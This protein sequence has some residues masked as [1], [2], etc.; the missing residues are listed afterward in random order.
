MKN[1]F[2][3]Q[4]LV[5]LLLFAFDISA[6]EKRF[7]QQIIYKTKFDDATP[8][9]NVASFHFGE[10]NDANSTTFDEHNEK[11]RIEIHKVAAL[12][13]DFK[14]TI[15][16]VE[17]LPT[18]NS[19]LL[20]DYLAYCKNPRK[21]YKAPT[22]IELLAYEVGRLSGARKIYGIDFKQG[23][24]YEILNSLEKP[25]P[26]ITNNKYWTMMSENEKLNP[27]EGIPFVEMFKINN[28]PQYL[29]S[30]I[31]INADYLTHVA[32]QKNHE[33]ADEA[34]KF[35]HRNLVIFS[36]L[37]QIPLQKGDRIFILM[38]GTHTA[39][40]NDFLKRSPKYILENVFDYVK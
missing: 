13:A 26:Q 23:Y 16:I 21:I 1:A 12:L 31:N 4:L 15:I 6:Q 33:G 9:L 36:N 34:A 35:Y 27:E 20:A 18:N 28:H 19:K 25:V 7:D 22:E 8:V 10:T 2:R 3:I 5:V 29:E 37:N 39:F 17:D 40:L 14:P 32:T 30:M 38:G 11:N 24:N